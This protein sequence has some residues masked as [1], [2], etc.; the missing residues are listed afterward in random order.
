MDILCV[1]AV[2]IFQW[3]ARDTTLRNEMW[4]LV[5]LQTLHIANSNQLQE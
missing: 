5:Q 1:G 2:G 4:S 3:I